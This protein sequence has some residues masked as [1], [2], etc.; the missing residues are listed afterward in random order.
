[1]SGK[2]ICEKY[3]SYMRNAHIGTQKVCVIAHIWRFF[4]IIQNLG[5]AEVFPACASTPLILIQSVCKKYA[6]TIQA[7]TAN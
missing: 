6:F 3:V 1:L 4:A 7:S 2:N 5:T